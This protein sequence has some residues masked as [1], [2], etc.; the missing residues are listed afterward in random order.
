MSEAA[1]D[2]EGTFREVIDELARRNASTAR[3]LRLHVEILEEDASDWPPSYFG[4][5]ESGDTDTS[6]RA[7]EILRKELGKQK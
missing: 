7:K 6:A 2:L 4:A 3:K 1:Y 5:F